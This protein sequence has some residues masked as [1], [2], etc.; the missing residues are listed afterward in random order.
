MTNIK[1]IELQFAPSSHGD[2]RPPVAVLV[3][4]DG[5]AIALNEYLYARDGNSWR[6]VHA[7]STMFDSTGAVSLI[8]DRDLTGVRH[9]HGMKTVG[10]ASLKNGL[11]YMGLQLGHLGQLVLPDALYADDGIICSH[12]KLNLV[13]ASLAETA[14][15]ATLT[16]AYA[17]CP[18]Y[19]E[20]CAAAIKTANVALS[21]IDVVLGQAIG[22]LAN[23]LK[24]HPCGAPNE[25]TIG[26]PTGSGRMIPAPTADCAVDGT[27]PIDQVS[28][29]GGRSSQPGSVDP[30][31]PVGLG[32]SGSQDCYTLTYF[33]S[34]DGGN[35][36]SI[37]N[38]VTWCENQA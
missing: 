10:L 20:T 34:W 38:Q 30:V 25:Q 13:A 11:R 36:W 8:A 19:P 17:S 14:G 2:D 28:G 16:A 6:E 35:T 21:A 32:G 1:R 7:R 26:I 31:D 9:T 29:S 12:E 3:S 27:T 4:I 22:D 37:T 18:E 24:L 23:C 33:S 5:R 15:I